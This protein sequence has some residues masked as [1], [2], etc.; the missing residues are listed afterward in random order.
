MFEDLLP[1][2]ASFDAFPSTQNQGD[3]KHS[4]NCI[5]LFKHYVCMYL[6]FKPTHDFIALHMWNSQLTSSQLWVL[7]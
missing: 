1:L 7:W 2:A 5:C 3:K 6:V 4:S